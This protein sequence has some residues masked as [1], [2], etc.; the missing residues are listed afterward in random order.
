MVSLDRTWS[1]TCWNLQV[2]E[3]ESGDLFNQVKITSEGAIC[4]GDKILVCDGFD[5][6]HRAAVFTHIHSDH[7]SDRFGTCMHHY[8]VYVSKPT[9]DLLKAVT[10]DVYEHRTQLH[11]IGYR[12]PQQINTHGGSPIYLELFESKHMLGSSQVML[13]SND[14]SILY[15]GD[16][17]S[18]DHPPKCDILVLDSTHGS[19]KFNKRID[20]DSLMRRLTEAVLDSINK[21]K[22]VC[23]H[24]HSGKLHDLMSV[25][26]NEQNMPPDIKFLSDAKNI[27]MAQVYDK[28]GMKIKD[29]EDRDSYEGDIIMS[30]GYPWIDFRTD[31]NKTW[32][33]KT[34][35]VYSIFCNGRPGRP[36]IQE[37]NNEV[38]I[39]SDEHAEFDEL[40]DYVKMADPCVVVTDNSRSKNGE[41]LASLV[42]SKLGIPSRAMP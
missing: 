20:G 27:R 25:L 32:R 8:P 17:S 31:L 28:Y 9:L 21:K 23:I 29:I 39:A 18:E 36:T 15:S 26:S 41:T 7:M 2:F 35:S 16:I 12:E 22:P 19:H 33:E 24:A 13:Q 10:E 42:C 11:V 34:Q 40:L 37:G 6:G 5:G 4:L 1:T 30:K 14:L 3:M 38:W